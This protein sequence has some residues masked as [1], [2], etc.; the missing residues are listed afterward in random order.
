MSK[1]FTL[2]EVLIACLIVSIFAVS[3]VYLA[4][5]EIKRV[6]ESKQITSPMFIAKSMMEE[7][8]GKPFGSLFSYNNESFDDGRGK[9]SVAPAGNDL[10]SI[11]IKHNSAPAEAGRQVELNTLRSRY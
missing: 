11:T 6:K 10:V 8:R 1:G 2:V 3:F 7:L 5:D 4:A 9:I